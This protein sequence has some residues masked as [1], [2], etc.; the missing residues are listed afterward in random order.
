MR[1]PEICCQRCEMSNLSFGIVRRLPPLIRCI[2][3][4]VASSVAWSMN[5]AVLGADDLPYH[6]DFEKE[7]VGK[8]PTNFLVLDGA[9][10]VKE[11]SGNKLLELPGSPLDT[12]AVQ[13]GPAE[14]ENVSVTA[15]IRS[16]AKGRRYPVFG[17][18]LNGVSGYRLQLSA[19]K[20]AIE[21]YKDQALKSTVEYEWKSGS[22]T[23]LRLQVRR[24]AD[25]VWKIEGRAWTKGAQEPSTW[26]ISVEDKE[27]PQTG[28]ASIFGSPFSG[29]PIQ[30]DD[31]RVERC[32]QNENRLEK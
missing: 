10:T 28:R 3:A 31:L 23:S 25:G 20:K 6:Q 14:A 16:T 4:F 9:F 18:G 2:C 1:C 7:T 32:N 24:L 29:T 12:Y 13:F 21:L 27:Q 8:V 30:F 11:E 15:C 5:S 26:L 19:A 22:W 17:V